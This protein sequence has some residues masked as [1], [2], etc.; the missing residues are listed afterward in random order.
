MMFASFW[1]NFNPK[2]ANAPPGQNVGKLTK[3]KSG[4]LMPADLENP[5]VSFADAGSGNRLPP[6]SCAFK[7]CC[8]TGGSVPVTR[9]MRQ[10]AMDRDTG[11]YE[12]PWDFEIHRHIL[13]DHR[14]VLDGIIKE[15]R[16]EGSIFWD[17]YKRHWP[18]ANAEHTRL[19]GPPPIAARSNTPCSCT[20]TT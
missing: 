4:G 11:T 6:V 3:P 20:T 13:T 19:Q 16:L 14:S 1:Q 12:H 18:S 2:L 10:E 17:V 9:H 7:K 15:C 8:W 5:E